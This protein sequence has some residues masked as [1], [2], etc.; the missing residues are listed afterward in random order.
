MATRFNN[1][2]KRANKHT[3]LTLAIM[4]IL[5]TTLFSLPSF[6]R[7]TYSSTPEEV[8]VVEEKPKVTHLPTPDPVK[9]L[10]MTS[11]VAG[12]PSWRESL[13]NLIDT[14]ELNAVVI[15]IKD[16]TGT[17]T[18]NDETLQNNATVTK[19]CKVQDLR[20]FIDE[21]H[22]RGIYVIG[23]ISVF[24]D[25]YY[26]T[27]RPEFAVKSLNTGDV[28]RDFKKLSFIDVGALPYW[29][30]IVEISKR[31]Y[32][33]GFDELNFDYVRYPSDGSMGDTNYTWAVGTTTKPEMLE[34]FFKY[35]H[36]NLSSLGAKTSVDLF[37]M[38]ATIEND[39]N[40]GQVL[41]R[42]LPYFDYVSP[43]VYPSHYPKT[44]NGFA[45]PAEHPYE[46][47]KIAMTSAV[48]REQL[49]N[50]A[51]GIATST[52]SKMR[53]WLQDFDLGADYD[54]DKV[55]AQIQATY[56]SGLTS[57]LVWN[58][59]NKYTSEAYLSE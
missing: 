47:V 23:R 1:M 33:L 53:P 24:Q 5:A 51:N 11:C 54:V 22:T 18:F 10:Y 20:K 46:V 14:T 37:G 57:W 56:D 21:L 41:E 49:W 4:V 8:M 19:G 58:A 28:W 9:A 35:L 13:A 6:F 31:S 26:T 36:S 59:G 38:T 52:P 43:M 16:A 2:L 7:S 25:P 39:M 17:I 30:Y 55:R 40:I 12:T 45:N 32:E 15:D 50:I 44:W 42:A 3:W 34:N 48:A 27:L 29:D